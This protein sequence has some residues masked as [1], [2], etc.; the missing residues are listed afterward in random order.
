MFDK[1][2]VLESW[3]LSWHL[4]FLLLGVSDGPRRGGSTGLGNIPKK[5][6]FLFTASL[7]NLVS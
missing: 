1:F 7:I 4:S 3:K 5:T 6:F 2:E